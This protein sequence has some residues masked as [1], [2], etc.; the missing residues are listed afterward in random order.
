MG[1]PVGYSKLFKDVKIDGCKKFVVVWRWCDF[2]G[3]RYG[4]CE[5]SELGV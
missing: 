3:A 1:F 2:D 4:N 5:G